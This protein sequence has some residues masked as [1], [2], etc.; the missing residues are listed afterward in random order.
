MR[1]EKNGL[2]YIGNILGNLNVPSAT[3][4]SYLLK[5]ASLSD[6][7]V[8]TT[9]DE[10]AAKTGLTTSTVNRRMAE[11]KKADFCK[12]LKP[13]RYMLNPEKL[14]PDEGINKKKYKQLVALYQG[15]PLEESKK[16]YN[17]SL[18]I[19]NKCISDG[20]IIELTTYGF[21]VK[22][23]REA[24]SNDEVCNAIIQ[25]IWQ[26]IFEY[27]MEAFRADVIKPICGNKDLSDNSIIQFG[28]YESP[29]RDPRN[30][31]STVLCIFY[32]S[33][34]MRKITFYDDEEFED[35][36]QEN[37]ED[38]VVESEYESYYKVKM[39]ALR[40]AENNPELLKRMC[41]EVFKDI[42]AASDMIE[43]KQAALLNIIKWAQFPDNSYIHIQ[44]YVT[45]C[46]DGEEYIE[47]DYFS[48]M[49]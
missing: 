10:I 37:E 2:E 36:E 5:H 29:A 13:G 49:S 34:K 45:E 35:D 32:P 14:Y 12:L 40:K 8:T 39:S 25:I 24:Y 26:Y 17:L 7:T 30:V 31:P 22:D 41:Q 27:P 3:V 21:K 46:D 18:Q 1:N 47:T 43:Q 15:A 19:D 28:T 42:S 6:N 48:T 4:L 38:E 16:K 33:D 20:R 44:G 11:L 9:L 23:I